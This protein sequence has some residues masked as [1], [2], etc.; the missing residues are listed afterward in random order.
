LKR[1][2]FIKGASIVGVALTGDLAFAA[3]A[4][5]FNLNEATIDDLQQ[6]MKNGSLTARK[7]A[8]MYLKRIKEIDKAGPKLNAIIELNPDALAVADKMDA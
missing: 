2:H 1:R 6:R 3:T 8:E 4:D 5:S 7:I